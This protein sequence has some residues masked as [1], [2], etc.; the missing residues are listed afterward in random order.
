MTLSGTHV[1]HLAS[2]HA[3]SGAWCSLLDGEPQCVGLR[4][5]NLWRY[6]KTL[7]RDRQVAITR[8]RSVG[9][10]CTKPLIL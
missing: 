5:I 4:K 10:F 6:D 2:D 9:T 3:L 1:L 7:L 8:T